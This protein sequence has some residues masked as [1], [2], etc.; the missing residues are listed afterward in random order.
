VLWGLR[1]MK[2]APGS[3]GVPFFGHTYALAR[4]VG[5]YPCT[6]DLFATWSQ[7]AAPVRLWAG[8][9]ACAQPAADGVVSLLQEPVRVQ[10]FQEQCAVIADPEL[11]KRVL[12]TNL[13]NYAKDLDFSYA[14]FMVRLPIPRTCGARRWL[15]GWAP[16]QGI[17]GTGLVTSDGEL[18][19][20]QRKALSHV[21]RNEIL[22][23]I[24]GTSMRAVE[25]LVSIPP[26]LRTCPLALTPPPA[27]S[28]L[29]CSV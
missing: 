6:W 25:R 13:S 16:L 19:K 22:D 18:W 27:S 2:T 24:I 5:R 20:K 7:A 15:T 10:I 14:P 23:D 8:G 12:N 28:A 21:F 9:A 4:A 3:L 1:G 29:N 11:M 17:L 26:F